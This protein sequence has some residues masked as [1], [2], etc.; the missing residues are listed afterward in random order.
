MFGV[1]G[2]V[3]SDDDDD[4][5]GGGGGHA[6]VVIV[7]VGGVW[8]CLEW[9]GLGVWSDGGGDDDDGGGH[10]NCQCCDCGCRRC[11]EVFG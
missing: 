2:V 10:A 4:D 8:R 11:L 6:N 1:F 3:W 9:I 7:G 5:D